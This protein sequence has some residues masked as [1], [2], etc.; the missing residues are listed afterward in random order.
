VKLIDEDS[1]D[2]VAITAVSFPAAETVDDSAAMIESEKDDGGESDGS[3]TTVESDEDD[4]ADGDG[5]SEDDP[6]G[7]GANAD[8]H[9]NDFMPRR[10]CTKNVDYSFA[11]MARRRNHVTSGNE[12][13]LNTVRSELADLRA[14][15]AKWS[16]SRSTV[17]R[18][19][20][21]RRMIK[22]NH[23]ELRLLNRLS[24]IT[25]GLVDRERE[26]TLY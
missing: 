20:Y 22:Y 2:E 3:T 1:D 5:E 12:V 24:D 14:K 13:M 18:A 21:E 26:F 25:A 11:G 19:K 23:R 4:G 7:A 17:D 10:S 15:R 6:M 16:R 8:V 9:I